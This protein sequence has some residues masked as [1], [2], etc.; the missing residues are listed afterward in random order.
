MIKMAKSCVFLLNRF[1]L[2]GGV[3]ETLSLR[4]IVVGQQL[5]YNHHCKFQFGEDAQTHEEHNK[6]MG[7]YMI[8]AFP[9]N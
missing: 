2:E 5:D 4:T 6:S 1:P 9:C 7:S 3:S 8:G